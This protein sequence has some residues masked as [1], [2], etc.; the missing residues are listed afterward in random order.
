MPL[1]PI[2]LAGRRGYSCWSNM[3]FFFVLF[4]C[5]FAAHAGF[6]IEEGFEGALPDFHT[7]QA[8]YTSDVTRVH[9]G[10]RSLRVT[11]TKG[12]GGAYFKLDGTLDF[13]SDYEYTLWVYAGTTGA[14]SVYISAS[15]GKERYTVS[16]TGSRVSGKWV[17]LRG[18]VR[19]R[20][21]R[22]ADRDFMLALSTSGES[23]F[24]DVVLRKAKIPD[25]A[26]EV[27]PRLEAELRAAAD[28]HAVPLRR[29]QRLVL[30]ATKA[31][32]APDIALPEVTAVNTTAV[33]VPA[34]GLLTYAIDVT[35]AM[36]VTGTVQLEPDSDLRPGLRAYVLSDSTVV[37]A[38]VV[39]SAPWRNI[40]NVETG[41]APSVL[42]DKPA[43]EVRLVEWRLTKGRHYLAVAGP[44]FRPAGV[45]RRFE[46]QAL[47]RPVTEPQY[48]FALFAD[49]H[50]GKGRHEWMNIKMDE[51]SI[52]ELEQTFKQVR[53]EG[54][55]FAFIAGDMTDGGRRDQFESLASVIKNASLPVYGCVGNHETFGSTSR[56]DL[57]ELVPHLFP[58]AKTDYVLSKPP[59]RFVVLDG[60]WWHD[61][62]GNILSGYDRSKAVGVTI[63]P[64]Q[65]EWLRSTLA[66]DAHTPTVV[67]WHYA[68]SN[69]RGVTSCGYDLGQP[70]LEKNVMKILE[71]SSNVVATL[72]GHMHFNAFSSHQGI[73]CIQ[74]AAYAEWPNMY[75]VF[76]VYADRIEWE[77][78]QVSNRGFVR[79]GVE[80]AKALNWMLSTQEG[81]LSG[82]VN[83]APRPRN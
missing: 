3:T 5:F 72:N 65:L 51:P 18:V 9:S 58:L 50:L 78:R 45:V 57:M 1:R 52:L 48:A 6:A 12:S 16:R 36:Y 69:R 71:A 73:A 82:T 60:S 20:Q 77:V 35:E 70:T 34:E 79:E 39:K 32:L 59:L 43:A 76:R 42:G 7:Y 15:D 24:D 2:L 14:V 37:A 11:P 40:G 47:D 56:K 27:W 80:P 64:E 31:V 29:G 53:N 63:K 55:D 66:A 83:L 19:A 54:A 67:L 26:I 46:L 8:T 22:S 23:W 41:P 25:P 30:D 75:R 74:N 38:P 33:A 49:T 62:E 4:I 81:D 61:R 13:T 21:W 44:H 28:R 10:T 17:Q 68:F